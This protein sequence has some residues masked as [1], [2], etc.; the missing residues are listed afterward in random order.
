MF[1]Y[2]FQ[3]STK[4]VTLLFCPGILYFDLLVNRCVCSQQA[5]PATAQAVG[6]R[7]LTAET[8]VQSKGSQ[9]A[10]CGVQSDNGRDF[11]SSSSVVSCQYNSVRAPY[12]FIFNQSV[13]HLTL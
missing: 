6:Q 1:C 5:G 8:R 4:V 11:S 9:C 2:A 10:N 13:A 7:L 3:S 12:S